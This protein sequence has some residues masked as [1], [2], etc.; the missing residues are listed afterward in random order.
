MWRSRDLVGLGLVALAALG[1]SG[2]RPGGSNRTG[3]SSAPAAEGTLA[4]GASVFLE[5]RIEY[6]V[7]DSD[8]RV[9][10][11]EARMASVSD[12]EG[13]DNH[14]LSATVKVRAG[15]EQATLE[16]EGDKPVVWHGLS[17]EAR[18]EGYQWGSPRLPFRVSK[19]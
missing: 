18:Y 13:H 2:E 7:A 16:L 11:V 1:C 4:L 5:P 8:V 19:K 9:T 6:A 17:L 15:D 10:L 12:S 3:P 14:I